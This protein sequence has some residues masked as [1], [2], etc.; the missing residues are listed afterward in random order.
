MAVIIYYCGN[1][2][3]LL[4]YQFA[5]NHFIV[6]VPCPVHLFHG[7]NDGL[8]Y[9]E[10]SIKLAK[11]LGKNPAKILTTIKGGEHRNLSKFREYHTALDSILAR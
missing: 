6:K 2:H 11:V 3:F 10:S 8:I 1:Y 4:K 7:D 9:Y 5:T